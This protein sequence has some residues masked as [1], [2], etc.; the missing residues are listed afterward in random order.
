MVLLLIILDAADLFI[1]GYFFIY[2][3]LYG[4]TPNI[5]GALTFGWYLSLIIDVPARF[6]YR[7]KIFSYRLA[8]AVSALV[9]F[10]LLIF[11]ISRII[12]I[13]LEE[14]KR[15]FPALQDSVENHE[16]PG[17]IADSRFAKEIGQALQ[18]AT[19][20]LVERMA[21][22]G[23]DLVNDLVK[24]LPD[25]TTALLVFIITAAYFTYLVPVLK[26]NAWRFFPVAG[27]AKAQKFFA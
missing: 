4:L 7:F 24:R 15:L 11:G 23:V 22:I 20:K 10:S 5:I 25:V 12:P 8:V 2:C 1:L 19:G 21:Q 13:V 17:F 26:V 3:L 27:R 9:T 6:L 14:G 16:V 18:D